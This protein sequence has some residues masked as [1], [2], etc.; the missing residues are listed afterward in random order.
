MGD[1]TDQLID[2][3][4]FRDEEGSYKYT[5][6]KYKRTPAEK[7]IARIRKEIVLEVMYGVDI[8]EA[9]RNANLKYGKGWREDL[10]D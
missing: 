8:N 9:R 7:R 3:E 2:Q 6:K 4:I 5:N 1:I 10:T